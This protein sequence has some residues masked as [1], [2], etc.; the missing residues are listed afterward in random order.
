[1]DDAQQKWVEIHID[2]LWEDRLDRLVTGVRMTPAELAGVIAG[3]RDDLALSIRQQILLGEKPSEIKASVQTYCDLDH[4]LRD[5]SDTDGG[6]RARQV[7][8]GE[9]ERVEKL[10]RQ[11]RG[12]DGA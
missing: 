9:V 7:T 12:T 1:M 2:R 4:W 10:L 11:A 8:S 5:H 3:A 6:T